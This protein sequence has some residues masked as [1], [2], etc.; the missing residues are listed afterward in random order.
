MMRSV[1]GR[2]T[3]SGLSLQD[4]MA[5]DAEMVSWPV[6]SSL[7]L[8][9][10]WLCC[11]LAAFVCGLYGCVPYSISSCGHE[12]LSF[13]SLLLNSVGDRPWQEQR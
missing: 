2:H 6:L 5:G 11:D 10:G 12:F 1:T 4:C 9:A 8:G 13:F 7:L 3:S